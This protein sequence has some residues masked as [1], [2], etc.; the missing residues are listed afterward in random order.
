MTWQTA[1]TLVKPSKKLRIGYFESVDSV[2]ECHPAVR[3]AVRSVVKALEKEGHILI[4]VEVPFDLEIFT[5]NFRFFL[6]YTIAGSYYDYSNLMTLT[7][8]Y[9]TPLMISQLSRW[10]V[11]LITKLFKLFHIAMA[12]GFNLRHCAVRSSIFFKD[13]NNLTY[14]NKVWFIIRRK[15]SNS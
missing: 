15:K 11:L 14:I 1:D 9:R 7:K 12:F 6:S 8:A 3:R 10:A 2:M 4:K 13:A 5:S